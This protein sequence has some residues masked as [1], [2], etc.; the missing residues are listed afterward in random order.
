MAGVFRDITIEWDGVDY[1]VTPSS[2][3][4]RRIEAEGDLSLA[5]MMSDMAQG[6]PSAYA[7]AF[8]LYKLLQSA[9]AKLTEDDVAAQ[10]MGADVDQASTLS[11][12]LAMAISPQPIKK[13]EAS[14]E[15]AAVGAKPTRKPHRK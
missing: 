10:L 12:A 6:R 11:Q 13:S 15:A 7:M 4:L 8:V 2:R 1:V 14:S 3:L 5:K 9:G